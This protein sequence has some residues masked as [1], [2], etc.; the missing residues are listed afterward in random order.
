MVGLF[1][2]GVAL[3]R[4]LPTIIWEEKGE[5]IGLLFFGVALTLS[6]PTIV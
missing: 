4:S 3:T 2:F 5:G 6:L 1:F